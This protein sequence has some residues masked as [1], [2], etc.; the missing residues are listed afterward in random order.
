MRS[1]ETTGGPGSATSDSSRLM[2]LSAAVKS[3]VSKYRFA[4]RASMRWRRNVR[5]SAFAHS[6]CSLQTSNCTEE[7]TKHCLARLAV[8]TESS[9]I[10]A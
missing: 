5:F 10:S 1:W 8:S 9:A 6:T 7:S 2:R 4:R 3:L